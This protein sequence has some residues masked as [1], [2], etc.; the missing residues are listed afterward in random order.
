MWTATMHEFNEDRSTE[1]SSLPRQVYALHGVHITN[2]GAQTPA[3]NTSAVAGTTAAGAS[4]REACP[5]EEVDMRSL[6]TESSI[7]D[8]VNRFLHAHW[9]GCG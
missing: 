4:S 1:R 3:V 8:E 5:S 2:W 7:I 9:E 6:E